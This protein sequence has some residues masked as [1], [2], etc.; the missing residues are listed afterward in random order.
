MHNGFFGI[1][2][3]LLSSTACTA[4]DWP[5]VTAGKITEVK[6]FK[7]LPASLKKMPGLAQCQNDGCAEFV[8]KFYKVEDAVFAMVPLEGMYEMDA[9][10]QLVNDDVKQISFPIFYSEYGFTTAEQLGETV[11]DGKT[12]KL[13]TSFFEDSCDATTT[14]SEFTYELL[15]GAYYLT[16]AREGVGC[17][18]LKWTT[19][20]ARKK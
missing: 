9:V 20:W 16:L 7:S 11:L 6:D 12:G 1:G 3:W 17:T 5:V 18:K 13:V 4:N 19:A 2:I 15:T 10:F 14:T 8:T